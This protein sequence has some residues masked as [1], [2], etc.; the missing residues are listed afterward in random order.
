[1]RPLNRTFTLIFAALVG[2]ALIA[3]LVHGVLVATGVS[4]RAANTVHGPTSRR[5]WATSAGALALVGAVVG[6]LAL[7][8]SVRSIGNG[9]RRGAIVALL[10]GAIAAINGFLVLALADGGP[11]SG[12]GVVGGAGAV[13]LG[14]IAMALGTIALARRRHFDGSTFVSAKLGARSS[15]SS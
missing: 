13:V 3:G 1:M 11:G 14:V 2:V 12:N 7:A 6:G 8:R 4:E 15:R 9:G 10:A 5:L